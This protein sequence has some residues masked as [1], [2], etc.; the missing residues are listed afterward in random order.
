MTIGGDMRAARG[1]F[2]DQ[3]LGTR[4]FLRGRDILCPMTAVASEVPMTGRILDIGCG[5][6]LFPALLASGSSQRTIVGCDPS[7]GKIAVAR[8]STKTFPN[9]SYIQGSVLDLNDGPYNAITILDVLYLLPDDLKRKILAQARKLIKDDGVFL[10]KT[11]D[12][13]PRWKFAVVRLEEWLMVKLLRYTF[14]GELHFRSSEQYLQMLDE[15]G[16]TAEVRKI[17]GWRPVP[18]RLFVCR[19]K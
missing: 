3:P 15:A 10:L 17:E 9:I 18:H 16:F 4:L 8:G 6:G 11:N 7:E 5:H 12:T 19:P 2:T 1:A 13:H 14:G